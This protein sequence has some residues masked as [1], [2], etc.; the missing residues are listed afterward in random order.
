[1][2]DH[3]ISDLPIQHPK[4]HYFQTGVTGHKKGENLKTLGDLIIENGHTKCKNLILKMDI[5]G[6]EWDVLEEI[7]PEVIKQFSQIAIEFHGL[8]NSVYSDKCESIAR[9]LKKINETHQSVHVHANSTGIPIW[10]GKL[11]LPAILEVTYVRRADMEGRLIQKSRQF[12][13]KI[14]QP[15]F[16]N[17][18]DMYLGNFFEEEVDNNSFSG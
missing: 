9:V 6:S 14:D 11:V 10:I 4:F 15:T 1:M 12:P 16:K 13:T 2:Y 18:P 5:E 8:S 3:T 17:S 7:S